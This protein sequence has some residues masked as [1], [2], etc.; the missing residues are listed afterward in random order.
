MTLKTKLI[1]I[2]VL[3]FAWLG[4]SSFDLPTSPN[5][6]YLYK[7]SYNQATKDYKYN[8]SID[9]SLTTENTSFQFQFD[10]STLDNDFIVDGSNLFFVFDLYSDNSTL[11]FNNVLVSFDFSESDYFYITNDFALDG[12][13]TNQT[14]GGFAYIRSNFYYRRM[15]VR[16]TEVDFSTYEDKS[17]ITLN[18]LLNSS[19]T[20]ET[21]LNFSFLNVST[22]FDLNVNS[23]YIP[24][25]LYYEATNNTGSDSNLPDISNSPATTIFNSNYQVAN[26]TNDDIS[27]ISSMKDLLLENTQLTYVLNIES[28]LSDIDLSTTDTEQ[29][30]FKIFL[31]NKLY[32]KDLFF[33]FYDY[34]LTN[35]TSFVNFYNSSNENAITPFYSIIYSDYVQQIYNSSYAY[36]Y[37][38]YLEIVCNANTFRPYANDVYTSFNVSDTAYNQGY[39]EGYQ[40]GYDIGLETGTNNGYN[41][42]YNIG[43][44]KGYNTGY[45]EGV[46]SDLLNQTTNNL[47]NTLIT[48]PFTFAKE[49]LNFEI[50]GINIFGLITGLITIGIVSFIIKKFF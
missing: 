1:T 20:K 21:S 25:Y 28:A 27:S 34:D 3:L 12:L 45:D 24:Y 23:S 39:N 49:A 5:F 47:F 15:V 32:L 42:G 7:M 33:I 37:C 16:F 8:Y 17:N 9:T 44:D 11:R 30:R 18:F 35:D 14:F 2:F 50:L 29:I 40:S 36:Y 48:T 6:N 13:I 22:D 31:K 43:Y 38:D 19:S 26:I 10:L 41:N 4:L 46:N